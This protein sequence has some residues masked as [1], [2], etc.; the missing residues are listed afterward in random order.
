ML[1]GGLGIVLAISGLTYPARAVAAADASAPWR[2]VWY[3][4]F[5]GRAGQGPSAANWEYDTGQYIFGTGEIET[6]TDSLSNVHLDG[7]GNLDITALGQGSSWTSGRIQTKQL[8]GA[9]AG[10]ELRVIASIK[11]PDPV[12]GL[13]TGPPSG[14]WVPA[15][16]RRRGRSTSWRTSTT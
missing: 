3:D 14:C 9:A 5:S 2:T 1:A 7:A 8:F 15:S 13:G 16:G 6:M 4:S 11:Q 12:A 10:G